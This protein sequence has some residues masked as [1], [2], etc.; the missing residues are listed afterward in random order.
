[1]QRLTKKNL[2]GNRDLDLIVSGV[3]LQVRNQH[4]ST[5]GSMLMEVI[6]LTISDGE[7]KSMVRL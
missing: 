4:T 6:C 2:G 1:M 5:P 3:A 7:Y